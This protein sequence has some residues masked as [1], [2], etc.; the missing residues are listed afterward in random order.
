MVALNGKFGD[1]IGE[2]VVF[3][4]GKAGDVAYH[5]LGSFWK[6]HE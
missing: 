5:A 6:W 4:G 1:A 2:E 3:H